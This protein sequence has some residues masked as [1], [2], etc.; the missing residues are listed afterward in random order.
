MG[1]ITRRRRK[2]PHNVWNS[3]VKNMDASKSEITVVR[4][5]NEVYRDVWDEVNKGVP[6][7]VNYGE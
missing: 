5:K 6:D 7:G 3:E 1:S 2:T 4:I